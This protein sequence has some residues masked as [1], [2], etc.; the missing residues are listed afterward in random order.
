M[1]IPELTRLHGLYA[2]EGLEIIYISDE[3]RSDLVTFR[4]ENEMG[5]MIARTERAELISPYQYFATPST[6]L[7]DRSGLVR[8]AWIV[9]KEFDELEELA[10]P[11]LMEGSEGH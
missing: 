8:E 2:E 10:A 4:K 7:L 9:P 5:G 6:Y 11:Y 1:Q 3:P